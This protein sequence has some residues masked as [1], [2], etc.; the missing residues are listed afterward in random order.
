MNKRSKPG[1]P[2]RASSRVSSRGRPAVLATSLVVATLCFW[3]W[4]ATRPTPIVPE[5]PVAVSS[6]EVIQDALPASRAAAARA[7]ISEP[8][9][10]ALPSR[11]GKPGAMEL[12]PAAEI[13]RCL[14]PAAATDENPRDPRARLIQV[15]AKTTEH[16]SLADA[17]MRYYDSG[18]KVLRLEWTHAG[19]RGMPPLAYT[20]DADGKARPV[21]VP[22]W[23][24]T[25]DPEFGAPAPAG[26]TLSLQEKTMTGGWAYGAEVVWQLENG[27]LADLH[28]TRNGQQLT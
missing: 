18:G 1:R 20:E 13:A 23:A 14:G 17:Q 24:H 15:I 3:N 9:P 21:E 28:W 25:I 4:Q 22:A 5:E 27:D 8:A 11:A 10:L 16:V 12:D 6:P 2:S 19:V 7:D 26:F